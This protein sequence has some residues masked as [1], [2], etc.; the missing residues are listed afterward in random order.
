MSECT[1]LAC[2]D[3]TCICQVVCCRCT[4]GVRNTLHALVAVYTLRVVYLL[5][6]NAE[7]AHGLQFVCNLPYKLARN[8]G[9]PK[10]ANYINY[11]YV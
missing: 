11:I 2:I 1:V 5:Y 9:V 8:V 4:Q 10:L 3:F 7:S 6:I